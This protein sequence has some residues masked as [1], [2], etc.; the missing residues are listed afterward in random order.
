MKGLL[1]NATR[2]RVA[3]LFA[4]G[5]CSS[6]RWDEIQLANSYPASD[7]LRAANALV[8]P[9]R[10]RQPSHAN[11]AGPG[12]SQPLADSVTQL[13]PRTKAWPRVAQRNQRSLDHSIR[14]ADEVCFLGANRDR[15]ALLPVR[16]DGVAEDRSWV[17]VPGKVVGAGKHCGIPAG[18]QTAGGPQELPSLKSLRVRGCHGLSLFGENCSRVEFIWSMEI[19]RSHQSPALAIKERRSFPGI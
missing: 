6:R 8:A 7:G 5:I 9:W 17:R 12:E 13:R 16:L 19:I 14:G 10:F 4:R 3:S 15:E 2:R 11:T 1:D 18:R